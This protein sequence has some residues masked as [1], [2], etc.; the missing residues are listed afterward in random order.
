M[1][2]FTRTLAPLAVGLFLA[3][4]G[5]SQAAQAMIV[6]VSLW[7]TGPDSM[8][9][10]GVNGDLS[11][12][13]MGLTADVATIPAGTVTFNV[14]NNSKTII[15]EMIMSRV[16]A[17]NAPLPYLVAKFKVDEAAASPLGEVSELEVG[18]NGQLSVNLTPGKYILYC[19]IM[20]HYMNGMWTIITVT[21]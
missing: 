9:G 5:A 20:G 17:D 19:N 13:T 15:H 7:D 2:Q 4:S 21:E 3:L 16:P 1:F 8:M 10:M 12:A 18:K 14:I 11:K 6:N